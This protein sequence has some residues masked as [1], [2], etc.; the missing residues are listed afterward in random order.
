[1]AYK[2]I[3]RKFR[4]QTFKEVIGQKH[5]TQTLKNAIRD[6]RIG[7]AFLFTGE[8]GVG[9]TSVARI[10]AKA[11]NCHSGPAVEPCGT[12]VSCIEITEGISIDVHEIDG[13]SNTG[14]D[15]IRV[16][17][18]NVRY[19]PSRERYKIYIIDEV[20]ML[21]TSAF[22][23]LLKTLEEP[24]E[25]VIFIF[26]TTE[27]H[28][29]PDTIISRCLRFDFKRIPAKEIAEHLENI[30]RNENVSISRQGLLLIARESD[31]SMRD[32]QTI[33]ERAISYCGGEVGDSD[34][35][36]LLGHV[37][38][39]LI[40][41]IMEAVLSEDAQG[42]MDGLAEV[43]EFGVDLKQF[44]YS[45]LELL[46]DLVM[47]MELKDSSKLVDLADE[48]L[49]KVKYFST[50]ISLDDLRRCFRLW[51]S[52]EGEIV[53]SAFP[54]IVLEVCL[55]EMVYIKRSIPLDEILSRIDGLKKQI[56]GSNDASVSITQ[57]FQAREEN[58]EDFK[59][60]KKVDRVPH[61][62]KAAQNNEGAFLAFVSEKHPSTASILEQGNIE[63]C[64]DSVLRI[65]FPAGSFYFDQIKEVETEKKLLKICN[66]FFQKEV[67]LS[68]VATNE[69]KNLND[70]N[71]KE[72]VKKK[73]LENPIIQKVVKTFNGK[74][75]DI[76]TDV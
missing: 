47:V 17:R 69:E 15:D 16:L 22:N 45:F 41:R 28:K 9:K 29:L 52:S 34:L 67:K 49:K 21:S 30:A 60:E 53:R 70:R 61:E 36:E 11:L 5:V 68:I 54:E 23:A 55:L 35:E 73:A 14:V 71:E 25:H 39:Q 51:F 2:V 75:V 6:G 72:L 38:R 59:R 19:M 46:R 37:D 8:R 43:Y 57:S 48:D 31:G 18:E 27:P 42:C 3:A 56:E 66:E 7:H 40:Y 64:G 74:I 4:P 32:A 12:C 10:L 63:M 33:L 62:S 50:R 65:E 1:M 44:Y 13:A 24:P 26:A 20:H 58:R 76:S